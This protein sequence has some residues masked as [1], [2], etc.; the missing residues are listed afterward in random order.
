MDDIDGCVWP[1]GLVT[2]GQ[3]RLHEIAMRR[4]LT[5]L[6]KDVENI[7]SN[8]VSALE[9]VYRLSGL[10]GGGIGGLSPVELTETDSTWSGWR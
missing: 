3:L 1:F 9:S 4:S 7:D 5:G 6:G 8:R 2:S 10:F